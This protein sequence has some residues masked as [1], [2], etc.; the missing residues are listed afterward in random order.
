MKIATIIGAR[1]Q[2]IKAAV[3]SRAIAECNQLVT[4]NSSR[5]TELIIHT[6][7]HYDANMSKVFFDEMQIPEPDYLLDI[8]GLS[9]GAMTGHML[10][11]VEEVL[12]EE[13]PDIVLVYGDTNTTLAGALA[14][15]KMH[16]PVAHVEAGLRSFNRRMPEEINRLLTDHISSYLFCPTRQAVQNLKDEGIADK[17]SSVHQFVSSSDPKRAEVEDAKSRVS[18]AS[19][20]E[21]SESHKTDIPT[22]RKSRH[23]AV[24]LSAMSCEFQPKVAL[25]GDVMLDAARYYQQYACRPEL[26]LHRASHRPPKPLWVEIHSS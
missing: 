13:K 8:H 18:A 16:I 12:V 17:S 24:S 11:G 5:L 26:E 6:G 21:S 14:A 22:G 7:Q 9:H 23:K 20:P 3:V 2:F 1:P 4:S 15:V 10:A 19:V 25:V